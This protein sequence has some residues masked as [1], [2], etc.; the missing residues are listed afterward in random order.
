MLHLIIPFQIKFNYA[1]NVIMYLWKN[2][3]ILDAQENFFLGLTP[4]KFKRMKK[5]LTGR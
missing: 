1:Y 5:K 2:I 4:R 3:M